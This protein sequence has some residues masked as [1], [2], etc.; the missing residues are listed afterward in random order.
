MMA[1]KNIERLIHKKL[2]GEI[3]GEEES[4]LL[5]HIKECQQCK[6]LYLEMERVKDGIFSL[7]EYFPGLGFNARVISEIGI[8]KRRPWYR[9][10]P[11]FG[12]LY[13]AGLLILLLTPLTNQVLSRVLFVAPNIVQLYD[14]I[15]L[16]GDSVFNVLSLFLKLNYLPIIGF[17][18][19]WISL[20]YSFGKILSKEVRWSAQKS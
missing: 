3:T 11:V 1:H 12:A 7:T 13:L 8:G 14:K 9:I 15:C 5:N 18:L 17:F 4:E 10:V 19:I 20:L 6:N 16:L 2:D